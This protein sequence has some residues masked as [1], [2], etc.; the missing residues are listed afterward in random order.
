MM[1][2]SVWCA[3]ERLDQAGQQ[4]LAGGPE[5]EAPCQEGESNSVKNFYLPDQI[6]PCYLPVNRICTFE[7]IR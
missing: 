7:I 2:E 1:S 6:K 3:G 5:P 4:V